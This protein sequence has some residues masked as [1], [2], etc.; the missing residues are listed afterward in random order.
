MKN[1]TTLRP[2]CTN[3]YVKSWKEK[4]VSLQ[5]VYTKTNEDY[6]FVT[7]TLSVISP[8][9]VYNAWELEIEPIVEAC[10][11]RPRMNG[12]D[13]GTYAIT[14]Q[15]FLDELVAELPEE[16]KEFLKEHLNSFDITDSSYYN[17][18]RYFF[19]KTWVL[20]QILEG[21]Y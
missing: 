16:Q 11:L 15:D 17:F 8:Q 18:H 19:V 6:K 10:A 14:A 21:N 3:L 9:S 12:T 7:K 5:E 2:F 4:G 13:T 1:N 20:S